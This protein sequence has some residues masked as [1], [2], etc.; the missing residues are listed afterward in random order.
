M[1]RRP[2]R[3]SS[4]F[5]LACF[6]F[7]RAYEDR[8][9]LRLHSL[10]ACDLGLRRKGHVGTSELSRIRR[11]WISGARAVDDGRHAMTFF[12]QAYLK[13]QFRKR[14]ELCFLRRRR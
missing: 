1:A 6:V 7:P 10:W 12:N 3:L 13:D 9:R 2:V 14:R 8:T 4:T 5:L 11:V